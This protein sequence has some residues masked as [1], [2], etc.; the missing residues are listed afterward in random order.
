MTTEP[1]TVGEVLTPV[2]PPEPQ[3]DKMSLPQLRREIVNFKPRKMITAAQ[4]I[5][6][7]ILLDGLNRG[8]DLTLTSTVKMVTQKG[9]PLVV[10]Q[11]AFD[12]QR[13]RIAARER[14]HRLKL[15]LARAV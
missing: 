14:R 9:R 1:T 4:L 3:F 13:R 8:L 7:R 12:K 15:K 5:C 2:V 6:L 10:D 11:Q